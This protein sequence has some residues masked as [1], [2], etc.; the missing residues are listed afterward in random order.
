MEGDAGGSYRL[1]LGKHQ[2]LAKK[3]ELY[4]VG[5]LTTAHE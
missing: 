2:C 1:N 4:F 3:L 5:D